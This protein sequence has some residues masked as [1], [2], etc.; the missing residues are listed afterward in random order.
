MLVDI[1]DFHQYGPLAGLE[2]QKN[3]EQKCWVAGGKTQQVPA[4]RLVD[5]VDKKVS[6]DLPKTSYFPGL[7][8]TD[9]N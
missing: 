9:L 5:F 4:Q 7:V 2:F 1:T 8:S 6:K 3:V